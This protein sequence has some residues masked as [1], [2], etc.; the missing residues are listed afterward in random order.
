MR[1]RKVAGNGKQK[2]AKSGRLLYIQTRDLGKGPHM[3][4]SA[5][6]LRTHAAA[7]KSRVRG[8]RQN[9]LP[10]GCRPTPRGLPWRK[11]CHLLEMQRV[12]AG[13]SVVVPRIPGRSQAS[14]D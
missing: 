6:V 8:A 13:T 5:A 7:I 10:G 1:E 2:Y 11:S 14:L 9:L 12:D 4:S 3:L